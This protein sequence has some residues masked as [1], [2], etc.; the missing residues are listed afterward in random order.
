MPKVRADNDQGVNKM[1][2]EFRDDLSQT[3]FSLQL[4]PDAVLRRICEPVLSFTTAL[5]EFVSNMISFMAT[6]KGAG[7]AA[8]QVGMPIRAIVAS[9]DDTPLRLVNPEIVNAT[10]DMDKKEEGC[11]SIPGEVYNI[12]RHFFVE[13]K[14]RTTSGGKLHFDAQGLLARILQH[15]IDHLDGILI[16]DKGIKNS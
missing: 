14:A 6:C 8:P 5:D 15:E 13:V 16:L 9:I 4:F 1:K 12:D 11:L 3:P 10:E 7:L 2:G